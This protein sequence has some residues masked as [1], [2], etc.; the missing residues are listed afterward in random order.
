MSFFGGP[1]QRRP[2]KSGPSQR[3][4]TL[5]F[6]ENRTIGETDIPI[7][8]ITDPRKLPLS[9]ILLVIEEGNP[10]QIFDSVWILVPPGASRNIP[11]L[12]RNTPALPFY[13]SFQWKCNWHINVQHSDLRSLYC[14]RG[15]PQISLPSITTHY[16]TIGCMPL[17]YLSSLWLTHSVTGSSHGGA[18]TKQ[19]KHNDKGFLT[20]VAHYKDVPRGYCHC[21]QKYSKAKVEDKVLEIMAF[22]Q[23]IIGH[24]NKRD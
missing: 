5:F 17:L 11:T 9:A 8:N 18:I 23:W 12:F 1:G 7:D 24:F 15:S 2:V 14:I 16:S 4:S 13:S 22:L 19:C 6:W 20:E 21:K 10:R 3:T